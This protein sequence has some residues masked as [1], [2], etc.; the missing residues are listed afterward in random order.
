MMQCHRHWAQMYESQQ[1][2]CSCS[3]LGGQNLIE[4]N[5]AGLSWIRTEM[6]LGEV[7]VI[8]M[9]K[10]FLET[11]NLIYQTLALT[12]NRPD[13]TETAR[14][15][16]LQ[17]VNAF[18]TNSNISAMTNMMVVDDSA[19]VLNDAKSPLATLRMLA[20]VRVGAIRL[21]SAVSIQGGCCGPHLVAVLH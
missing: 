6:R 21:T 1:L 2:G 14:S 10:N 4:F 11:L 20:S 16:H 19:C 18:L 12:G 9:L 8:S 17:L 5:I 13:H 7:L 15:A 3:G